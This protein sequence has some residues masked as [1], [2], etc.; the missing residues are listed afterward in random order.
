MSKILREGQVGNFILEK[1]VMP[2]GMEVQMYDSKE[3]RIYWDVLSEDFPVVVLI[4]KTE[5]GKTVWMSDAPLEQES[6]LPAVPLARG[7][8]LICGL[9]IGLLPTLIKNKKS[10]KHIDIVEIN[11]EVIELVFEQ[12]KTPKMSVIH[13]DAWK[14]LAETE[15]KYDFVHVDIWGSITAPIKEIARAIELASRCLKPNGKIRCWMQELYDRIKDNLPKKPVHS[16]GVGVYPPC[17]ICGKI[18]RNDYA[19]LCMDCADALGL[20]ELF[21]KEVE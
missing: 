2:K 6:I 10:V 12:I 17:L 20:S 21:I 15:N 4:E 14:Y 19:G 7:D 5:D 18:I 16:S 1:K 13:A 9:G 11:K 3:G 8:V